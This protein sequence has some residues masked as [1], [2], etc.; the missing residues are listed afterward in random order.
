MANISITTNPTGR[1]PDNK[2]FFGRQTKAL[3]LTRPKYNKIGK[4]KDY[5]EFL[6]LLKSQ[7]YLSPM[8]FE[9]VGTNFTLLL[10]MNV[11]SNLFGICLRLQLKTK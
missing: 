9:T 3:D 1:S 4:E 8:N 10:M 7:N 5:K 6:K 11:I 2:F